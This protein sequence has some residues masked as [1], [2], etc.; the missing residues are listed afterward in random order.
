MNLPNFNLNRI[1]GMLFPWILGGGG[2]CYT[3]QIVFTALGGLDNLTAALVF[4]I[5]GALYVITGVML[6]LLNMRNAK[7]DDQLDNTK[8]IIILLEFFIVLFLMVGAMI[9]SS[10]ITA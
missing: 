4:S 6:M 9:A 5:I 8:K 1:E 2:T 3:A 7:E 10:I